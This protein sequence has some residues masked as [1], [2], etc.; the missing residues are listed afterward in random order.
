MEFEYRTSKSALTFWLWCFFSKFEPKDVPCICRTGYRRCSRPQHCIPSCRTDI[1][2]LL[3]LGQ[4]HCPVFLPRALMLFCCRAIY[5]LRFKQRVLLH[6]SKRLSKIPFSL[7]FSSSSP[8]NSITV[9][10]SVLDFFF[11]LSVFWNFFL[12]LS[13]FLL[14]IFRYPFCPQPTPQERSSILVLLFLYRTFCTILYK[15]VQTHIQIQIQTYKYK[16]QKISTYIFISAKGFH[17]QI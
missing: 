10:L 5:P 16:F 17:A 9:W 1:Y 4:V 13:D 11:I 2:C 14:L 6:F 8:E 3:C 15:Q 7:Y 12:I